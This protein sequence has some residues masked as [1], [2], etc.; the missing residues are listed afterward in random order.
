MH[1][2]AL[3]GTTALVG[4]AALQIL[5]LASALV[6]R[7]TEGSCCQATTQQIFF[8]CLALVGMATMFLLGMRPGYWLSSGATLS[9]MVLAATC[10]FR[11][12]RR[13]SIW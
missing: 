8:A 11:H 9:L 4:L 2:I 5:G 3:D 13:P 10:D 6:A 7:L 12:A 1:S